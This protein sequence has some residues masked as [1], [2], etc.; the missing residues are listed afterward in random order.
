MRLERYD[1]GIV[2]LAEPVWMTDDQFK[3][4]CRFIQRRTGRRPSVVPVREAAKAAPGGG[5][6]SSWSAADRAKL[7]S[8]KDIPTLAEE[9]GRSEMSI[10][11]QIGTFV[12]DYL[13][14]ARRRGI[15]G[16]PTATTIRR[17]LRER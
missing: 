8:K 2:D 9:L 6:R 5:E 4:F 17:F 16:A 7:L 12:P 10:Q 13:R 3:R 11:M 14:W 1:G 15:T